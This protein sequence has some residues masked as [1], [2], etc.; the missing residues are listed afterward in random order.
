MVFEQLFAL[1]YQ[2]S[3]FSGLLDLKLDIFSHADLLTFNPDG[4]E[5]YQYS[6]LFRYIVV[7]FAHLHP[8]DRSYICKKNSYE[9]WAQPVGNHQDALH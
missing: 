9:H 8:M 4:K 2:F 6:N 3:S 5:K 1:F 7:V